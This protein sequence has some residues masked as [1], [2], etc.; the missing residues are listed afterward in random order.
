VPSGVLIDA[1]WGQAA[2]ARPDDQLAVLVSRLRSVVGRDR[3]EHHDGGYRLG[4]DWLD[5]AELALARTPAV[6]PASAFSPAGRPH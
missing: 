6:G 3:I 2:P 4:C 5:A 1:I